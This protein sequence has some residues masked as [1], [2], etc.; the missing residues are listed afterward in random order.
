[1]R[2]A[3]S[4]HLPEISPCFRMPVLTTADLMSMSRHRIAS[5]T[6]YGSFFD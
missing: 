6:G 4:A 2:L 1:V 5:H 3:T